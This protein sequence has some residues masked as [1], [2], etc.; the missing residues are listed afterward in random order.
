MATASAATGVL[1]YL[2]Q[3]ERG[4]V[5]HVALVGDGTLVVVLEVL[6]QRHRVVRDPHHRAQVV[7]KNLRSP[8]KR[9]RYRRQHQQTKSERE[10]SALINNSSSPQRRFHRCRV[11]RKLFT[12]A[13]LLC[14]GQRKRRL[15]FSGLD[16]KL[17][18][19]RC[20]LH[21]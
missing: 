9:R 20:D 12:S 11:P 15:Q 7:G 21:C 4:Q 18:A 6:L 5:G 14:G 3:D 8:E 2:V 1:G 17:L 13:V 10:T 19:S 16:Q